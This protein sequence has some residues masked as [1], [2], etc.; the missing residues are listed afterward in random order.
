[1]G[2]NF[3]ASY[4][5]C[6]IWRRYQLIAQ[7]ECILRIPIRQRSIHIRTREPRVVNISAN[8]MKAIVTCARVM[9]HGCLRLPNIIPSHDKIF[10]SS[11]RDDLQSYF[12]LFRRGSERRQEL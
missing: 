3:E 10:V 8:G 5:I 6:K 7:F 2:D 11:Q 4:V 12:M 1:M 9:N